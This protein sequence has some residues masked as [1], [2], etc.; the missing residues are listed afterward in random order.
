MRV[1]RHAAIVRDDFGDGSQDALN[2]T[3]PMR[4]AGPYSG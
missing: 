1:A 3:E 2:E 4:N